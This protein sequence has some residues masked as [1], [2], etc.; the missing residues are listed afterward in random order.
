MRSRVLAKILASA[1]LAAAIGMLAACGGTTAK[2]AQAG[3]PSSAAALSG[4]SAETAPPSAG[5]AQVPFLCAGL[6]GRGHCGTTHPSPLEPAGR[7]AARS[8]AAIGAR[9]GF[10]ALWCRDHRGQQLQH[11]YLP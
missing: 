11:R 5:P 3:H 7:N 6:T 9:R 10:G 8:A 2:L 1:M 4:P